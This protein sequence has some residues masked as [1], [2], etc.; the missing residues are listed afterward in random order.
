M[1]GSEQKAFL[2]FPSIFRYLIALGKHDEDNETSAAA[3]V[4]Y[5]TKN[6]FLLRRSSRSRFN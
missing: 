5:A 4:T 1:Q 3:K 2:D 6:L